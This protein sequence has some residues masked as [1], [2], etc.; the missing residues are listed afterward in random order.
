MKELTFCHFVVVV[1]V[2]FVVG[3]TSKTHRNSGGRDWDGYA[4]MHSS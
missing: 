4:P 1:C 2:V 3:Y